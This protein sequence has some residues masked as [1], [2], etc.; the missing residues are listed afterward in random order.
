MAKVTNESDQETN[1]PGNGFNSAKAVNVLR[2]ES[3]ANQEKK[4]RKTR[5]NVSRW[6]GREFRYAMNDNLET[7]RGIRTETNFDFDDAQELRELKDKKRK[8]GTLSEA[9]SGKLNALQADKRKAK[10][11]KRAERAR[12]NAVKVRGKLPQYELLKEKHFGIVTYGL[13][14]NEK[15]LSKVKMS[16]SVTAKKNMRAQTLR[17]I[18]EVGRQ[19][20]SFVEGNV[21]GDGENMGTEAF[22]SAKQKVTGVYDFLSETTK[23]IERGLEIRENKKIIKQYKKAHRL[24]DKQFKADVEYLYEDFLEKTPDKAE[25]TR[26]QK[27]AQKE[28]IKKE[29]AKALHEKQG[30]HVAEYAKKANFRTRVA[31]KKEELKAVAK[32]KFMAAA[33]VAILVLMFSLLIIGVALSSSGGG[34]A[35]IGTYPSD[36]SEIEASEYYF[37]SMEAGLMAEINSVETDYP[38]YDEYNYN[39]AEIGHNSYDLANYL[40]A[41]YRPFTASEVEEDLDNIFDEMYEFTLTPREETRT[42]EVSCDCIDCIVTCGDNCDCDHEEEYTVQILDVVLTRKE[43]QAVTYPLL[44]EEQRNFYEMYQATGGAI[45]YFYS[46]LDMNWLDAIG[47]D[48]LDVWNTTEVH[49]GIDINVP[50][51]T[52]VYAATTEGIVSAVGYNDV[53]GNYVSIRAENGYVIKFAHLQSVSV[54]SGDRVTYNTVIG[55]SGN[56]GTECGGAAQLHVETLDA[57]GSYINPVYAMCASNPSYRALTPGRQGRESYYGSSAYTGRSRVEMGLPETY[58]SGDAETLISFAEQYIGMTY[59]WGGSSPDTGFDCSGF[60]SYCVRESGFY[61]M[62]RTSAQGIYQVYCTPVSSVDAQPGDL[63]FFKG[64]NANSGNTITHVGIYCG[65]GVMLHCGDPIRYTNL[66]TSFWT[67]HLYGYGHIGL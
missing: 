60:V 23:G 15:E 9:E 45:Q 33:I 3:I 20:R 26:K 53:F 5:R 66:N 14:L 56:E 18:R 42:R 31:H 36:V 16:R 62:E 61:P 57:D 51:G 54:A 49:R 40:N 4:I 6:Q 8:H 7:Q 65:E 2:N 39:I 47:R 22:I 35:A 21:R 28:R 55:Q 41:R 63:V 52:N 25:L 1:N 24:E 38:N 34:M 30:V 46:P 17:S 13:N 11:G 58:S 29:Y 37:S 67:Q 27:V 12:I 48:Y 43:M 10:A 19:G 64:T 32:K 59:V 50:V 44:T